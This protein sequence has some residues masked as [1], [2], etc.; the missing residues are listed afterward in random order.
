MVVVVLLLPIGEKEGV[1]GYG[2]S[3]PVRGHCMHAG[4]AQAQG[5]SAALGS[6]PTQPKTPLCNADSLSEADLLM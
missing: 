1:R 5:S 2:G 3:P 6:R 4:P